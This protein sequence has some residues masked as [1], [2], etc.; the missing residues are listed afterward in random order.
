MFTPTV[1][2]TGLIFL[3]YIQRHVEWSWDSFGSPE[4]GRI[5]A[6]S[7]DHIK[8][9]LVEIEKNLNDPTEWLD[10]VILAGDGYARAGGD[11]IAL[12]VRVE[13]MLKSMM[14]PP[15]FV[16]YADIKNHLKDLKSMVAVLE[17]YGIS[18]TENWYH[19]IVEAAIGFGAVSNGSMQEFLVQLFA[20]QRKNMNRTWPDWR[21]TDPGKAI[22]HVR[23]THD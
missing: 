3:D 19:V 1:P 5:G 12:S 2:V 21:G 18:N 23:G 15:F 9:E 14:T 20:K 16:Y 17:E 6:G 4:T 11:I 8:K 7:L 22:E 10:V 13:Q